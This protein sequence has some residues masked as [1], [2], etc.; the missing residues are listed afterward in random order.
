[1]DIAANSFDRLR[2]FP[3]SGLFTPPRSAEERSNEISRHKVFAAIFETCETAYC[4]VGRD[5]VIQFANPAFRALVR[6]HPA[7]ANVSCVAVTASPESLTLRR[8]IADVIDSDAAMT[9]RMPSSE[10]PCGLTIRVEP[11]TSMGKDADIVL[12]SIAPLQNPAPSRTQLRHILQAKWALS[13]READCAILLSQGKSAKII[14]DERG[15][16]LPTI[17][18]QLQAIREKLGT[19]SSLEAAAIIAQIGKPRPIG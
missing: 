6:T 4:A 17:R 13:P 8:V 11:L 5:R 19:Q 16:S 12:L 18:T 9:V 10:R 3:G 2:D 15:V 7:L 1:M 14:A